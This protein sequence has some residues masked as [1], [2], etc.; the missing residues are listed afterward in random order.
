LTMTLKIALGS[1]Q[2]TQWIAVILGPESEEA[3]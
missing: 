2:E 1:H 3:P